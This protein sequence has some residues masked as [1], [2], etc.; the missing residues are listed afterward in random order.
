MHAVTAQHGS[1][2]A[3]N[4]SR[5][6]GLRTDIDRTFLDLYVHLDALPRRIVDDREGFGGNVGG[7]VAHGRIDLGLGGGLLQ[8]HRAHEHPPTG[9]AD[10][11]R[12]G[13]PEYHAENPA[14][15]AHLWQ[16][17]LG[18]LLSLGHDVHVPVS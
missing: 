16:R 8:M 11:D 2:D 13:E 14:H 1:R 10:R 7:G 5:G 18:H 17:S 6:I 15:G 12:N 4:A 9:K 3:S